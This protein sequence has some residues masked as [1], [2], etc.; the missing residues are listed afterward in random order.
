MGISGVRSPLGRLPPVRT[1][2]WR[3]RPVS[4]H[5]RSHRDHSPSASRPSTPRL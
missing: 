2:P 1:F 3:D 5:A 4:R